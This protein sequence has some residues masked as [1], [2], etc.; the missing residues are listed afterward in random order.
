MEFK[1]YYQILGVSKTATADDIK[2]QYRRLAHKYHPD[3]SKEGGAEEKFKAMK[4]AYEVL[5]DSEKRKAY[6]QMGSGYHG[7]DSF[8]PPPEWEFQG[9][10]EKR[11]HHAQADFSDFFESLFGQHRAGARQQSSFSEAGEDQHS[12]VEITLQDAFHGAEKQLTLSQNG[13]K[14]LLNVRIPAGIMQGQSIRLA[15]QGMTGINGG[16]KGDLYLEI[17]IKKH[18]LFTID[19]KDIFLQLPV[20]PW[21]AAL[22]EK[23]EVPTLGGTIAFTLP[24]NAQTGQKIRLKGR[25]LPG[26]PAGDQYVT[27]AIYIPEAK[28]TEQKALY[29]KM[30]SEM[31]FNPRKL[32]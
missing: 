24:A 5:K 13:E 17:H 2:K 14:R 32:L 26:S 10:Q 9:R 22:G 12:K 11:A 27:L 4:E 29:E 15:G 8:N 19:K 31:P 23:I 7:G 20:T 28:T 25:G 18:P 30:K 16:K 21:E 1:D 6:D 3:V